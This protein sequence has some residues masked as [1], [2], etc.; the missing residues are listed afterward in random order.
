[1]ASPETYRLNGTLLVRAGIKTY[2][3]VGMITGL[4]M[5]SHHRLKGGD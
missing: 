1:M 2:N 3:E 4:D 5:P